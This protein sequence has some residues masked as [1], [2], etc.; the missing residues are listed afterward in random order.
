MPCWTGG[1]GTEPSEQN[2]QQS[3]AFGLN[4]AAHAGQSRKNWQAL[5]GIVMVVHCPQ[6][7]QV[8]WQSSF[9]A[10]CIWPG[11]PRWMKC[12]PRTG[13]RHCG[14]A[15]TADDRRAAKPSL[16]YTGGM[17]RPAAHVVLH[18]LL[19]ASLV[20]PG[21]AMP[22]RAASQAW[23]AIS[24]AAATGHDG[25]DMAQP[26]PHRKHCQQGCCPKL[27]CDLGA[28]IAT[29]CLPR[30][31][32]LPTMELVVPFTF[33]WRSITPPTRLVETL[34]RPPIA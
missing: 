29:G 5:V 22:A 12:N 28:C 7:G 24:A 10:A 27:A 8:S 6:C 18:L 19:I 11:N 21:I 14:G 1:H 16:A 17:S 32:S 23:Q 20:L 25:M 13:T 4:T 33:S 15:E 3:P 2:T 9:K 26:A 34:L 30:F 31:A